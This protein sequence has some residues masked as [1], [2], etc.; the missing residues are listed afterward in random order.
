MLYTV[1]TATS[2][3]PPAKPSAGNRLMATLAFQ[4]LREQEICQLRQL[5]KG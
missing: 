1:C 2:Q 3:K 4:W 5:S